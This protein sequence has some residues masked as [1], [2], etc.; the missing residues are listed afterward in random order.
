M[1]NPT[2]KNELST[3]VDSDE[4]YEPFD[5][6][7]ERFDQMVE[8]FVRERQATLRREAVQTRR[9]A[10]STWDAVLWVV[11]EAG[12]ARLYDP[13]VTDR[14]AQFSSEQIEELLAALKRLKTKPLGRNVTDKLIAGIE[15]MRGQS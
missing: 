13:W 15:Q 10:Q 5:Q 12:V 9:A 1:N 14:L 6:F 3:L 4:F 7:Y 11:R 8:H 2:V